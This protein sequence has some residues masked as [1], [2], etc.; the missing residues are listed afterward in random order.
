[1]VVSLRLGCVDSGSGSL[2]AGP[3]R[4]PGVGEESRA[5]VGGRGGTWTPDSSRGDVRILA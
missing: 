2:V 1:M 5:R 3:T 4:Q